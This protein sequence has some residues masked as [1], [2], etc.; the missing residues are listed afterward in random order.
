MDKWVNARMGI[1][2]SNC[3]KSKEQWNP[4]GYSQK[5]GLEYCSIELYT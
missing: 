5:A 3:S 1:P 2:Y 4:P